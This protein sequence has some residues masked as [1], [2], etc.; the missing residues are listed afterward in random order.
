MSAKRKVEASAYAMRLGQLPKLAKW[1][2][3]LSSDRY[4]KRRG[5]VLGMTVNLLL[6]DRGG[7]G[8]LY[9]VY[10]VLYINIPPLKI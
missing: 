8:A 5:S 1:D 4:L 7:G 9:S 6:C 3:E 10:M 2:R